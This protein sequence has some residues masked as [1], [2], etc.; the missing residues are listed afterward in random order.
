MKGLELNIIV[1]L[2]V[3]LSVRPSVCLSVCL[4]VSS[5]RML[6]F[7]FTWWYTLS[8]QYYVHNVWFRR[9]SAH[10]RNEWS[11][12]KRIFQ[13][14]CSL[15]DKLFLLFICCN[16]VVLLSFT[17]WYLPRRATIP[18]YICCGAKIFSNWCMTLFFPTCPRY[19][20]LK[21]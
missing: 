10:Q 19:F 21:L 7:L 16:S 4:S 20:I 8:K 11:R 1:R 6:C 14:F 18:Y 13:L 3:C 17:F 9:Q 5:F 12:W 15:S 2:P